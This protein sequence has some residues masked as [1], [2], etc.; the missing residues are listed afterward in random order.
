MSKN[1][2]NA[3]ALTTEWSV[4]LF[5]IY[6]NQKIENL[7]LMIF[8]VLLIGTRIH[9]LGIL[10]HEA[11]HFNLFS[12]PKWNDRV[13]K[14]FITG[15]VFIS[16]D[17]Y[18]KTHQLHHQYSLT[19]KDPT[20]T[21]KANIAIYDF[22]K[23]KSLYFI[24]DLL[25]ILCG[26]GVYLALSDL[27]RNRSTAPT[28][29][30]SF[31]GDLKICGIIV[32]IFILYKFNYLN[33]YLIFWVLPTLTVLPLLNYWRTISEHSSLYTPEPTRTVIYSSFLKW[34]ITPYNINY[35]L[36]HHLFPKKTWYN[37]AKLKNEESEKLSIGTIT[38]GFKQLWK[39][40]VI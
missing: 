35:H 17:S 28:K 7:W 20:H 30:K 32:F 18:R 33:T 2:I 9:A 21:R 12:N 25:K 19:T 29:G 13:A 10:M 26:Y 6:L 1:V 24:L 27:L 8:S 3:I 31:L 40:F 14:L 39:E 38:I 11:S 22:P 5:L 4:I 15:P 16:L 36:E 34:L 23:K 37:L